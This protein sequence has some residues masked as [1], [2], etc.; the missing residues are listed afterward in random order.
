M[1]VGLITVHV[2]TNFGSVLQT[3]ATA[4]ILSDLGN[5]VEV[6]NYVPP[7]T[8]ISGYIR[9]RKGFSAKAKAM[10]SLP[11][12]GLNKSIYGGFL[13]K[14]TK[15]T[16]EFYKKED[17]G[18]NL[19]YD[20]YIIGSDQVWNS[21]HN[22][23]IDLVYYLD[24]NS[25]GKHIS[26]SSSF[27]RENCPLVE[28]EKVKELLSSFSHISAREDTGVKLLKEMGFENTIQTIDPTFLLDRYEWLKMASKRQVED[29]YLLVYT[30]YNVKDKE[31]IFGAA[32]EIGAKRNLKVVTFGWDVRKEPLA[33]QTM[34]FSSP[35]DFL[36]LMQYADVVITN[37]FHGTAFSVILNKQFVVFSPS[38]F[39]TRISSLLELTGLENRHVANIREADIIL[40]QTIDYTEINRIIEHER[41]RAIRYLENA[42]T[43]DKG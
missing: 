10:A 28:F 22:Q 37:S 8:T 12:M 5:E 20:A 2:G 34:L 7:R 21:I 11:I 16:R 30:P 14:H 24:F 32:R 15:L 35:A 33:D 3:I 17:I 38:H 29:P 13:K 6:I 25:P 36:S 41:D 1:K 39:S 26:F 40:A 4:K 19:R 27:G 18:K 42:L 31:L 43:T 9:D 23:G